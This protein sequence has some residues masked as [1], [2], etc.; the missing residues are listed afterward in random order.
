MWNSAQRDVVVGWEG[1][2][3]DNGR[4]DTYGGAPSLFI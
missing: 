4:M 2:L 1:R 3:G